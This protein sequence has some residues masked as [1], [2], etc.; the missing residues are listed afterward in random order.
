MRFA[1][2]AHKHF[3]NNGAMT[4]ENSIALCQS[5]AG[6][7]D[8]AIIAESARWGDQRPDRRNNPHTKADWWAEVNGYLVK[9]Y[10]PS[11]TQIVLNQLKNR[12][13][14]PNVNAP[15]FQVNGIHQ[16]GGYFPTNARLTMSGSGGAIW[17]TLDGSDPRLP[18]MVPEAAERRTL[19][20]ENAAKRVF[21]PSA[22]IGDLWKRVRTF[23]DSAWDLCSGDRKSVV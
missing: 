20:P 4:P 3:F 22:N 10:F 15:V 1:D 11:R 8:L 12:G 16:H 18:G 7:I 6:E 17:Y 14:Y 23:D 21:V 2:R 13:L 19:V 9:S 5:R